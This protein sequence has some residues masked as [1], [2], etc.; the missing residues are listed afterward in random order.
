MWD[1][2]L[3]GLRIKIFFTIWLIDQLLVALR[4]A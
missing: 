2:I 3:P 1:Q 4:L